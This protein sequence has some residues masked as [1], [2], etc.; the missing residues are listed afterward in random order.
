MSNT[1]SNTNRV[2]GEDSYNL[3][4]HTIDCPDGCIP[5]DARLG[6]IIQFIEDENKPKVVNDAKAPTHFMMFLPDAYKDPKYIENTKYYTYLVITWHPKCPICEASGAQFYIFGDEE[7]GHHVRSQTV[8][9]PKDGLALYLE[10][11]RHDGI[12]WHLCPWTK[13]SKT[14]AH[15]VKTVPSQC[16]HV[17]TKDPPNLR[18]RLTDSSYQKVLS[19][20]NESLSKAGN[21]PGVLKETVAGQVIRPNAPVPYT[22]SSNS[23]PSPPCEKTD[24][25]QESSQSSTAKQATS[26]S[27]IT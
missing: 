8:E 16:T 27:R 18:S 6:E 11:G 21:L 22:N 9:I 10:H 13:V 19:A 7:Q 15:K 17:L 3:S 26:D 1:S 2:F 24:L 4:I 20:L 25:N 5:N 14:C 12:E 23:W